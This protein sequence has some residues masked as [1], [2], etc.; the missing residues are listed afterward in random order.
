MFFQIQKNKL[1]M[2]A[3]PFM[4]PT[5]SDGEAPARTWQDVDIPSVYKKRA[6][7]DEGVT[8]TCVGEVDPKRFAGGMTWF[9]FKPKPISS[10]TFAT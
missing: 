2:D 1:R 3:F 8:L 7:G 10:K 6:R 5:L 4:N 9:K